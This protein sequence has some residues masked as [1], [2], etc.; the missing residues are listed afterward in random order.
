M[1]KGDM[2]KTICTTRTVNEAAMIST[3][4]M[5][6]ILEAAVGLHKAAR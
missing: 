4:H 3:V 2:V 6:A 5:E 1:G